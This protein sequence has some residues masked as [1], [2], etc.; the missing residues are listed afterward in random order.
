MYYRSL[1]KCKHMVNRTA[2]GTRAYS[3]E[4]LQMQIQWT[5]RCTWRWLWRGHEFLTVTAIQFEMGKLTGGAWGYRITM[6]DWA[7][8]SRCL[9]DSGV[10]LHYAIIWNSHSGIHSSWSYALL[11]SYDRFTQFVWFLTATFAY[12]ILQPEQFIPTNSLWIWRKL[13]WNVDDRLFCW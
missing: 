8:W 10:D 13:Q 9:G 4:H 1:S 11:P 6:M 12:H 2:G 5:K 3:E 7:I